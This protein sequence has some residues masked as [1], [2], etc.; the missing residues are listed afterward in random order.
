MMKEKEKMNQ[1]KL[2]FPFLNLKNLNLLLNYL[3]KNDQKNLKQSESVVLTVPPESIIYQDIPLGEGLKTKSPNVLI[4]APAY[5]LNNR[6]IF[7]NFI[8][9]LFQPY[10]QEIEEEGSKL[11]CDSLKQKKSKDFSLMTHQ[12]LV[13]DYMNLYTPYRG[14][15]LFHGLGAGKTCGSIAI[16]EGMKS[17]KQVFVLTPALLKLII[18]KN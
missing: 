16:A 18:L 10:K 3:V 17:D 7:V 4:K 12:K 5:Y 13:R 11:T 8:T 2:M 14:I 1:K 6:E 15:L 9:T